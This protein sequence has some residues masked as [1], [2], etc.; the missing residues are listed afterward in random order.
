MIPSA[1]PNTIERSRRVTH[2]VVL[3]FFQVPFLRSERET[4]EAKREIRLGATRIYSV[5]ALRN[6][7]QRSTIDSLK[8]QV[9]ED[10]T[11]DKDDDRDRS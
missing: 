1:V 9:D 3:L 10:G 7:V 6:F 5:A 11:K 8:A 2:K 4:T